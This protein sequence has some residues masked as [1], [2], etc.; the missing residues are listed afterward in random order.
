MPFKPALREHAKRV[1]AERGVI[2][3]LG[4]AVAA[5]SP[6]RVTLT[7]GEV[8]KGHTVVWAAGLQGHPV[9]ASLGLSEGAPRPQPMPDLSLPGHPEVFLVGDNALVTDNETGEALPQLGSVAQ[10][11]GEQAAKNIGL[12][13]AGRRTEAFKYKDKGSMAMIGDGEAVVQFTSG[14]S[15]TGRPAWLAWRGVHLALLAGGEEKARTL[16]EWTTGWTRKSA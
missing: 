3:H 12:L 10:Q 5:I 13:A 15:I 6:T 8:I 1:L 11:T 7:S 4:A 14:R 9:V 2:V 16:V